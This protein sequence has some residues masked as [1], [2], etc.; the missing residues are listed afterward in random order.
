MS[1]S[2]CHFHTDEW[3]TGRRL[4]DGTVEHVC[5]IVTG[6][7]AEGSWTWIEVPAPP[8]SGLGGLAE[9]L[10][11]GHE[12]PAALASL[13]D[14]WFE[15]GL[16]ERA[17]ALRDPDGFA[18]MVAQWSHT[19]RREGVQYSASTY[20]GLTLGRLSKAGMLAYHADKGTGRWNYNADMS[21]WC[22]LPAAPW[23]E[24]TSWVDVMGD[25]RETDRCREYVPLA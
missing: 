4:S 15:F 16:V 24:R 21:W 20:L 22:L 10:N 12:L 17:Y 7:P 18:R 3:S 1:G 11:L 14:G 8:A 25:D 2:I 19:A 9:E 5:S 13:G 23:S 6:H